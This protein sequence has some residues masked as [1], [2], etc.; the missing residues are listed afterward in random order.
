[1]AAPAPPRLDMCQ[2]PQQRAEMNASRYFDLCSRLRGR[3]R[4]VGPAVRRR[5]GHHRQVPA[6][7]HGR[8]EGCQVRKQV[9]R[10]RER[11]TQCARF[12]NLVQWIK[13]YCYVTVRA[14]GLGL[15]RCCSADFVLR[16]P[17]KT[18]RKSARLSQS[19]CP[20]YSASW[21]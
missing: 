14:A 7:T 1:M 6:Q 15:L 21:M 2:T 10:V 16:R 9:G 12:R 20:G 3:H 4:R 19:G 13:S 8:G 17:V 5:R 11:A 18:T